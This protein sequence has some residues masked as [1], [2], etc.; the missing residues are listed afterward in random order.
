MVRDLAERPVDRLEAAQGIGQ[1]GAGRVADGDVVQSG[2]AV[3]LGPAAG[4]LPGVEADVVVIAARREE[5]DV[6]GGAPAGHAA[7]LHHHVESEH[8]DVEGAH[9]V[10]V[11]GAQVDVAD[12]H[13]R[14]DRCGAV[15]DGTIGPWGRVGAVM[16]TA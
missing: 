5:E 3:R 8:I 9:A 16:P 15:A 10:D 14:V 13:A 4:R 2:D 11:G 12:R 1:A 6:A 7:R